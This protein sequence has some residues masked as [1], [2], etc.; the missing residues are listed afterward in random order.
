MVALIFILHEG[1]EFRMNLGGGMRRGIG[2]NTDRE[3]IS[4]YMY[5]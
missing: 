2:K 1:G 5:Y 4:L 3:K